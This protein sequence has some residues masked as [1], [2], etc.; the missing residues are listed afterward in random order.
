[1][2]QFIADQSFWELFPDAK[3]GVLLLRNYDN[4]EDSPQEVKQLLADSHD[5]AKQYLTEESFSDN[6]IIQ[7]LSSS[8]S[9]F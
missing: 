8:L 7:V 4:Q 1:M 6:E 5:I 2:T 9:A 3:L